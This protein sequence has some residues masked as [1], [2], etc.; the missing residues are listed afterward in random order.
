MGL[1]VG[2][3]F[4]RPEVSTVL[5][6]AALQPMGED[7]DSPMP[8]GTCVARQTPLLSL[9]DLPLLQP[10]WKHFPNMASCFASFES[11]PLKM[12]ARKEKKQSFV[13]RHRNFFLKD[14]GFSEI[15]L[16]PVNDDSFFLN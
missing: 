8:E 11:T 10:T 4:V 12:N 15:C 2:D 1:L 9:G 3:D 14:M 5:R 16:N 7:I 13:L 6:S